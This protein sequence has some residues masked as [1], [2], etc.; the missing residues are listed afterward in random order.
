VK[1]PP[2]D[3]GLW[4]ACTALAFAIVGGCM[5]Y[6]AWGRG[7]KALPLW[8]GVTAVGGLGVGWG[9]YTGFKDAG[10]RVSRR[11][12]EQAEDYGDRS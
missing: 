5:G 1:R 11:R 10:W 12:P 9:F 6:E 7:W 4:A 3:L 8:I 2:F